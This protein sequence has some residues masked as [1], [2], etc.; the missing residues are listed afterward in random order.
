MIFSVL[1]P[2]FQ[3]SDIFLRI[4]FFPQTSDFNVLTF[5]FLSHYR[6]TV[7]T[8]RTADVKVCWSVVTRR[9]DP[10][11]VRDRQNTLTCPFRCQFPTRGAARLSAGCRRRRCLCW[12]SR[13]SIWQPAGQHGHL[14]MTGSRV[15]RRSAHINQDTVPWVW[16]WWAA[17]RWF[18]WSIQWGWQ[19]DWW[20]FWPHLQGRQQ[21]QWERR[22]Q[23]RCPFPVS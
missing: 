20:S 21:L 16:S 15:F 14:T 18:H 7:E 6:T 8:W 19:S 13:R 22:S 12:R 2:E 17:R 1:L 3:S 5:F 11:A 9:R 4:L 23:S 10:T